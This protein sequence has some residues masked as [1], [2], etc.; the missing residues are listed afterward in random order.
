[1]EPQVRG[2]GEAERQGDSLTP[3]RPVAPH[4]SS[5]PTPMSFPVWEKWRWATGPCP[6][7][8]GS[9]EGRPPPPLCP[10]HQTPAAQGPSGEARCGGLSG[11]GPGWG[12]LS[13]QD[14]Q[15]GASAQPTYSPSARHSS[16]RPPALSRLSCLRNCQKQGAQPAPVG[17]SDHIS[18]QEGF[19]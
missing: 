16:P 5:V 12:T 2:E 15:Q 1:M 6:G 13:P 19:V 3:P 4:L 14:T 11:K 17:L 10:S 8:S 7:S 9:A 18:A